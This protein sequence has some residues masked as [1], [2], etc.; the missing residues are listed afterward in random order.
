MTFGELFLPSYRAS[1]EGWS[2]LMRRIALGG[3]RAVLKIAGGG[4][5]TKNVKEVKDVKVA[6]PLI[7]QR[8]ITAARR[9]RL[10]VHLVG[11]QSKRGRRARAAYSGTAVLPWQLSLHWIDRRFLGFGTLFPL[12]FLLPTLKAVV[13]PRRVKPLRQVRS[14]T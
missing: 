5:T 13:H 11:K 14:R 7:P 1:G 6:L 9:W 2:I 3:Q 10:P 8:S 12:S 4:A